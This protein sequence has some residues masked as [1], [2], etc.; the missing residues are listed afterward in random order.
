MWYAVAVVALI[1]ALIGNNRITVTRYV[2]TLGDG[3]DGSSEPGTEVGGI[4][5]GRT[6]VGHSRP[7]SGHRKGAHSDHESTP[8]VLRILQVSDLHGKRFGMRS[9]RLMRRIRRLDFDIVAV[10]GD[11]ITAGIL[12]RGA[13]TAA[14]LVE[15]LANRHPVYF[16]A[17]NHEATSPQF[18]ALERRLRDAG[19]P[20]MRR[21]AASVR[22]GDHSFTLLGLD[23]PRFFLQ[24]DP[25]KQHRPAAFSAYT[26]NLAA[27]ARS[28]ANL[29]PRILLAHR[30]ELLDAYARSGVDLVLTGHVHGGQVR[31]PGLGGLLAPDQ[32]LFPRFDAGVYRQG[33]TRMVVSRGLGPSIVPLR[34]FN[35]P[36]LVL[37]E[38]RCP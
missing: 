7:S 10:T 37:V 4:A 30:P 6:A 13:R 14:S 32:G 25:W 15:R 2:I 20:V 29:R 34:V 31:I 28:T 9:W 21:D 38:L 11:A 5:V 1:L 8:V 26:R 24:D 27:L 16:V 22:V 18:P 33:R 36:E 19:V 3:S 35:P 12:P 23:D 17:G